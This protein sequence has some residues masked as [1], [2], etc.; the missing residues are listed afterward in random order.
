MAV[1]RKKY[2][3][4]VAK[5]Y[6]PNSPSIFGEFLVP[7]NSPEEA[8][9]SAKKHTP[10]KDLVVYLEEE[11]DDDGGLEEAVEKKQEVDSAPDTPRKPRGTIC[12]NRGSA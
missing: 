6:H 8:F 3:M 2:G 5:Y 7:G 12:K 11:R 1:F 10:S 4:F 9:E